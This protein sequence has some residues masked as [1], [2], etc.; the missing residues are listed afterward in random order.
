MI[1]PP[2]FFTMT[3]TLLNVSHVRVWPHLTHSSTGS[4]INKVSIENDGGLV[5]SIQNE[6]GKVYHFDNSSQ[7][8]LL[9]QVD[10][11]FQG[12]DIGILNL[13]IGYLMIF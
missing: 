11:V 3:T 6:A 13:T 4:E 8:D 7:K 1:L 10:R 5:L 12:Y 9:L 2:I